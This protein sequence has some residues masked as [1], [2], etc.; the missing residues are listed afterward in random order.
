MEVDEIKK[1]LNKI[2]HKLRNDP[3]F[4]EV[5]SEVVDICVEALDFADDMNVL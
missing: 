5:I 2:E 1:Y 4:A 3:E